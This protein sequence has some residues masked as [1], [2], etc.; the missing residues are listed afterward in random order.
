ML[1]AARGGPKLKYFLAATIPF[2]A[3]SADIVCPHPKLMGG[4]S[5]LRVESVTTN[6]AR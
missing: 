1:L 3:R 4:C 2:K 5:G 6:G